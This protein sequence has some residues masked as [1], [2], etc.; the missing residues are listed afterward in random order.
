MNCTWQNGYNHDKQL[1]EE[2]EETMS[3]VGGQQLPGAHTNASVE[4]NK[5]VIRGW[6]DARNRNDVDAGVSFWADERQENIRKAF[7][8]FTNGFP[9]I[10]VVIDDLIGEGDK[11]VMRW[12]L[13]GTH[14]GTYRGVE[15]TGKRIEWT[16]IDIY[17][18]INGRIADLK[19]EWQL[20]S[21]LRE[22]AKK[23][24]DG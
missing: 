18:V 2:V 23:A 6:I 11:V 22:L 20:D 14:E 17:T 9:D 5:Q 3:E 7:N 13:R 19:R 4:D 16:A 10:H 12:R 15:A 1:T 8:D 24:D 21:Y